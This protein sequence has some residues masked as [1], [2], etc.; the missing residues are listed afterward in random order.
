[1]NLDRPNIAYQVISGAPTGT[2]IFLSPLPSLAILDEA[3]ARM[4]ANA[5]AR[6][7]AKAGQKAAVD[8]ELSREHLIFRVEPAMSYVSDE[9][10]S[11]DPDFWRSKAP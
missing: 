3:R 10:A 11:E 9:F 1:M 6:A 4:P 5:E 2:Y 8:V 7:A